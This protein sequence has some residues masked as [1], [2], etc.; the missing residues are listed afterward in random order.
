MK[1]DAVE[2]EQI[3]IPK[4]YREYSFTRGG[5][6]LFSDEEFKYLWIDSRDESH[7]ER[8]EKLFNIVYDDNRVPDDGFFCILDSDNK[9]VATAH[10]QLGEHTPDSATVHHVDASE[11][12]RGKK[13]GKA[14]T[15]MVMRYAFEKGI[16]E[17]YLTTDDFR[18]PAVNLYLKLG[19]MPV[20]YET[21]M[22]ERWTKLIKENNYENV[23]I[24]DENGNY[25]FI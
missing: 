10:I 4:E 18:V 6:E 20:L 8:I 9:I 25:S 1:W 24:I 12:H 11:K 15:V 13:L 16:K 21:D 2:I 5:D 14:V 22:R 3:E 17:V 23:R 19:F 7:S